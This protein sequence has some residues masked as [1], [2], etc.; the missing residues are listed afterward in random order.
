MRGL[1]HSLSEAGAK[2]LL[3]K[4]FVIKRIRKMYGDRGPDSIHTKTI[5]VDRELL[6]VGSD[7]LYPSY[8]E[9]H[10]V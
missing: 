9:E 7:N 2:A 3:D 1:D 5:C 8:N 4:W 10:G 6:Y